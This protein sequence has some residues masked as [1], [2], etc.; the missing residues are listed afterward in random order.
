MKTIP[1]LAASLIAVC[2][3]AFAAS[4]NSEAGRQKAEPCKACHGEAGVSASP[5]FPKLAGQ[6]AD[7]LYTAL[8]HYKMGKRKNPI[9]AGQVATL[10]DADMR[11]LAAYFSGQSGL[12]VKY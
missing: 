11:N 7:Y 6:H 12:A 2:M 1:F 3:P 8:R 10:S 4:G 9:M 5:D